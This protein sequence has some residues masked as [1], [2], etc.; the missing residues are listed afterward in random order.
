MPS[1]MFNP[2]IILAVLI[3]LGVSHGSAFL[4]GTHVGGNSEKLACE[5]RVTDLKKKIDDANKAIDVINEAWEK[6]IAKVQDTYNEDKI[7][8]EKE[9]VDLEK[10]V[11]DYETN[12]P[13]NPSCGLDQHDF[14]SIN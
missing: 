7:A 3:G 10:K 13:D 2:W 8:N 5:V 14:D 11:T 9:I 4:Y 1:L 12:L 6:A